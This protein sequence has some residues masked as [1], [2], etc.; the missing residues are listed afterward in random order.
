MTDEVSNSSSK[1]SAEI[2][3]DGAHQLLLQSGVGSVKIM[4]LANHLKLS[5]T[6]FY[7]HFNDREALL[8]A[9]ILRWENQ[10]TGNLIARTQ[11]YAETITEAILNLF[12]CW[13]DAKLFDSR[14]DF[15]IRNWAH[16][17]D[18]LKAILEKADKQRIA[19]IHAMFERFGFDP[20]QADVRAHT[21][22]YTQVGYVSMMVEENLADRIKLIPTY[23]E[24]FSGQRPT[25]KE[26][27]RFTSRHPT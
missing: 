11:Q 24:S 6:G 9:L 20:T 27:A 26:L 3:L 4:A 12:D 14:M 16:Q 18:K 23:I 21:I 7:W 5:R 15:A 13:V 22:Y 17:S 2:W 1:G 25:E 10:N 8:D 19:S